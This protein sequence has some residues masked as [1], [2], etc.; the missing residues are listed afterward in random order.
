M[1]SQQTSSAGTVPTPTAKHT[2]PSFNHKNIFSALED[3][4]T[5]IQSQD[6]S[7][8]SKGWITFK[9]R[10]REKR[11]VD[12]HKLRNLRSEQIELCR[13]CNTQVGR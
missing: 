1:N 3:E 12:P 10:H 13:D 2:G 11:T 9:K 5:A 4:N 8:S 6:P 7:E